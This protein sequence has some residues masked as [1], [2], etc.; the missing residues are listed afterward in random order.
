[1]KINILSNLK[2]TIPLRGRKSGDCPAF[3]VMSSPFWMN[4]KCKDYRA[5]EYYKNGYNEPKSLRNV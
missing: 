2:E 5:N 4:Q 1:M 3:C